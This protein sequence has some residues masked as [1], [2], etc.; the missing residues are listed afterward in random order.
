MQVTPFGLVGLEEL[1]AHH[2]CRCVYTQCVQ[3]CCMDVLP[4][5]CEWNFSLLTLFAVLHSCG[6]RAVYA[7]YDSTQLE[8]WNMNV[9]SFRQGTYI[10]ENERAKGGHEKR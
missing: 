1:E 4:V 3:S 7:E 10:Y 2:T 5:C 9:Y 8:G 6:T